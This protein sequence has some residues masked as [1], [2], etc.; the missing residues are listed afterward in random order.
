MDVDVWLQQC[1]ACEQ[2]CDPDEGEITLM[3]E[4]GYEG[5]WLCSDCQLGEACAV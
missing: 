1:E 4:G 3:S 5:S 2:W